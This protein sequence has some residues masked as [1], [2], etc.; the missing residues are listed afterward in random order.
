MALWSQ[1]R[2]LLLPWS[3]EAR[4]PVPCAC[5]PAPFDATC[6]ANSGWDFPVPPP[7]V[8][9]PVWGHVSALFAC[10]ADE[11]GGGPSGQPCSGSRIP[12]FKW[13]SQPPLKLTVT[14]GTQAWASLRVFLEW[15]LIRQ[16][17]LLTGRASG[18]PRGPREA[19]SRLDQIISLKDSRSGPCRARLSPICSVRTR[20]PG[21]HGHF[22]KVR[23]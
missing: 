8:G 14:L 20:W 9:S 12:F 17:P 6:K 4:L 11:A 13:V 10:C 5:V 19:A 16:R 1:C 18:S 22:V 21:Q 2:K 7:S 23:L 3:S 15:R